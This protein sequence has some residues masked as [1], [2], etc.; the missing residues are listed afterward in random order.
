MALVSPVRLGVD[1][2]KPSSRALTY[3]SVKAKSPSHPSR[4]H[5]ICEVLAQNKAVRCLLATQCPKY[6]CSAR[7]LMTYRMSRRVSHP[8]QSRNHLHNHPKSS[9]PNSPT[10]ATVPTTV[11]THLS[12]NPQ[13]HA[14]V[15][16][17]PQPT[18][19]TTASSPTTTTTTTG[20]NRSAS[21]PRK[22]PALLP[23]GAMGMGAVS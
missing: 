21:K 3:I 14:N 16:P 20:R 4:L 7:F 1:E 15:P 10:T 6:E 2:C 18:T 13:C 11:A 12:T 17:T 8:P 19:R 5:N 9:D 23:K 22:R